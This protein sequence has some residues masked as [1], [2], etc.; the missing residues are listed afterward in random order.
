MAFKS[1]SQVSR[2]KELVKNGKMSQQ[3]FDEY[4]KNTPDPDKLPERVDKK[5]TSKPGFVKKHGLPLKKH[6]AFIRGGRR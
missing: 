6:S 1:K 3:A 4:M 2:F 5:E